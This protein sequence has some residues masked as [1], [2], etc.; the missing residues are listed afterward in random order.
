MTGM[1]AAGMLVTGMAAVR[2]LAP[3]KAPAPASA[4]EYGRTHRSRSD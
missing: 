4:P 1:L 3:W 2:G